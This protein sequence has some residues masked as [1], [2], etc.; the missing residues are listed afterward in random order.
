[1]T[2][3]DQWVDV[4]ILMGGYMI[5]IGDLMA[6]WANDR[7][8]STLHCVVNPPL[9]R[10]HGNRCMSIAFFHQRTKFSPANQV[11]ICAVSV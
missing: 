10:Q 8:I 5:S 2:R 1:M 3:Q 11:A 7:W 9:N 6:Q 4:S